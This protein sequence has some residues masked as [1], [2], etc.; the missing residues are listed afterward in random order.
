MKYKSFA[1]WK[2][3]DDVTEDT[4]RTEEQALA[5]CRMLENEGWGGEGVEFPVKTWVE[6][7]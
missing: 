2:H 5:V 4:H 3:V 1:K 7:C 6:P